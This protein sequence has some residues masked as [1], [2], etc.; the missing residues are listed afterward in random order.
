MGRRPQTGRT[1]TPP[2]AVE[3]ESPEAARS[4]PDSFLYKLM[5]DVHREQ[6]ATGQALSHLTSMV[7][8]QGQ[9]M[10]R[11]DDLRVEVAKL[12]ETIAQLGRDM[13]T[14]KEKLDKV[15]IWIA[16][17]AAVVAFF[18]VAVPLVVRTWP[19][20]AAS[21]AAPASAPIVPPQTPAPPR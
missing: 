21:T 1:P 5:L 12:G 2:P 18:V 17:A 6:G 16:G 7:E 20:P 9:Q 19:A 4:H 15:R 8:R 13:A 11:V 3:V 14:T 10:G